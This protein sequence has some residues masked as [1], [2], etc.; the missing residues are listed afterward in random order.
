M[1]YSYDFFSKQLVGS[2]KINL[3]DVF[4]DI[5]AE[6]KQATN[7][8]YGLADIVLFLQDVTQDFQRAERQYIDLDN[9]IQ[10]IVKKYFDSKSVDNPFKLNTTGVVQVDDSPRAPSVV[11]DGKM[12]GKGTP[13]S[14]IFKKDEP[15][16]APAP[17]VAAPVVDEQAAEREYLKELIKTAEDEGFSDD[18]DTI[19]SIADE[20]LIAFGF[21]DEAEAEA[22]KW[23]KDNG[24]DYDKYNNQ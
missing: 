18:P 19:A 20:T 24:F 6:A 22:R 21:G 16:P 17:V 12:K 14:T 23:F 1:A 2:D 11:K 13:K 4:P 5:Q 8:S 3:T 10:S 15:A 7:V 9:A